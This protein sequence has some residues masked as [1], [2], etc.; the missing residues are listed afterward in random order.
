[1]Q[2][3]FDN[4]DRFSDIS[5]NVEGRNLPAHRGLLAARCKYFREQLAGKWKRQAQVRLP[6]MNAPLFNA[7]LRYCYCERSPFLRSFRDGRPPM[8]LPLTPHPL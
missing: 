3:V 1:M 8:T 6:K 2:H 4:R 7:L 5:F